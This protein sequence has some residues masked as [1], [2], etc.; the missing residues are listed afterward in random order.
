MAEH[1]PVRKKFHR[2]SWAWRHKLKRQPR[3]D[4]LRPEHRYPVDAGLSRYLSASDRRPPR[5]AE[6]EE[7]D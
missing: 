7:N 1:R 5:L 4:P 3:K 2:P 6:E